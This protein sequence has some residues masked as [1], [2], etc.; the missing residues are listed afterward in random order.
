ML[1]LAA[2]EF[3]QY[4]FDRIFPI[5]ESMDMALIQ[6]RT[7]VGRWG[8]IVAD[9]ARARRPYGEFIL[10]LVHRIN[11][12][13]TMESRGFSG[14]AASQIMTLIREKNL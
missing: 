14:T 1:K 9:F 13:A 6:M 2:R 10:T 5:Y 8:P 7:D 12:K 11:P 3:A 4:C